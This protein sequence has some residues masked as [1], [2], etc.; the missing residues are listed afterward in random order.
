MGVSNLELCSHSSQSKTNMGRLDLGYG[1][2]EG[3]YMMLGVLMHMPIRKGHG[4][5]IYLNVRH[6]SKICF[7]D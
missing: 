5:F 7:Q 1:T 2:Q 4:V 3:R 6:R